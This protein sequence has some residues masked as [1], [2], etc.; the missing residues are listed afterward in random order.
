[1]PK[2]YADPT[3]NMQVAHSS[4]RQ[5]VLR[6]CFGRHPFGILIVPAQAADS[7]SGSALDFF[8]A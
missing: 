6:L 3:K 7:T 1:M 5:N 8:R 4:N 2:E